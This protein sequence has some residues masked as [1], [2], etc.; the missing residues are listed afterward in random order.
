MWHFN[1]FQIILNINVQHQDQG[2]RV[3]HIPGGSPGVNVSFSLDK[4]NRGSDPQSS[5]TEVSSLLV[6]AT[7]LGFSICIDEASIDGMG[8]SKQNLL[9]WQFST[10]KTTLRHRQL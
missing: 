4:S 5:G 2:T 8:D 6:Y 3:Q 10:H 7:R 9:P 1:A